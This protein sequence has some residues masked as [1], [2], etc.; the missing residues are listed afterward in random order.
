M[1]D[2]PANL[3]QLLDR[4]GGASEDKEHISLR[5]IM[6]SV[7]SR[8]FGP[9]LLLAGLIT[10]APV[11]GD[12]PGMPTIMGLFVLLTAGQLFLKR[13]HFW[14]PSWL[15]DRSISRGKVTASL[16]WLRPAGRFFD[17]LLR[18]RL[19]V[20]TRHMG[21]Y[22]VALACI[23]I[24]AVMPLMELIPFSA[25]IA[26]AALTAFGL[27]LIAHDGLLAVIAFVFTAAAFG[28]VMYYFFF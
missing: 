22:A 13:N 11:I 5:T 3:E 19:T 23:F 17:R 1:P 24:A 20:L 4:I 26:G 9:L 28:L 18:Q 21:V 8:S 10:L 27:S 12:I 7:G 25:N 2:E 16:K 14:L 15:L 6:E